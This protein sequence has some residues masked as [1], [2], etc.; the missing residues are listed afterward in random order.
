M[1]KTTAVNTAVSV[2]T[3]STAVIGQ[4]VGRREITIVN[5]SAN[6]VYLALGAT[7]AMNSGIRLNASGGAYTTNLWEGAVSAIS[8][9][10]AS[11]VTVAEY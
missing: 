5:D 2:G 7:A 11:V 4:N 8:G 6:T 1:S 10:A 3:S 9:V